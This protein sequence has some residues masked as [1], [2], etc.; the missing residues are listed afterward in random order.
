MRAEIAK[1]AQLPLLCQY[2]EDKIGIAFKPSEV[3]GFAIM[4]DKDEFVA[5]VIVSNVRYSAGKAIDCEISCAT[6][7]SVAWRPEVCKAVFGYIFDQ[8]GAVRCTSIVR[9]NNTKSRK[10]LEALNFQLEG[11][12]RKGYDGQKDALIYGLLAEEC[13]FY[14]GLDG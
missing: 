8:I 11:N 12:V 1:P 2:L 6:E 4:S 5:G 10:F 7:S 3:Q 14:G 9:K 13:Q